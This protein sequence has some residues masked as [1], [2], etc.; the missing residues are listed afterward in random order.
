MCKNKHFRFLI[1]EDELDLVL[2]G[3]WQDALEDLGVYYCSSYRWITSI[4]QDRSPLDPFIAVACRKV[5]VLIDFG[6]SH[7]FICPNLVIEAA[8]GVSPTSNFVVK[9][10][11]GN[12]VTS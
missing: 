1:I 11:N 12:E 2:D 8:L 10:G 7:N 4:W 9:V 3:D 6:A 5:R